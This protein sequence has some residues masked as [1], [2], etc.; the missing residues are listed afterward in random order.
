MT[1]DDPYT[2][3]HFDSATLVTI[4]VQRDFLSEA[5]HGVPGTTEVLPNLRAVIA[6]FRAARRP[7][8]HIVRLYDVGGANAE[9]S[10]RRLLESGVQLVAP[11]TPGSQLADGLAPPNAPE[12]D[13]D[14]LRAGEPQ[15]LG[16]D[17]YALFKP[18]WGAFYGTTLD[19]LLRTLG[20]DTLV[21]AG[22]NLPNCPRASIIEASERDYRVILVPDA[23]SRTTDTGLSEIAGLGVHLISTTALISHLAG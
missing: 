4:D 7:V 21:F 12:L 5:P 10:R 2:A 14:A 18:R 22:C 8:I 20:V 23:V 17:E 3:P 6:A 16:P 13:P 11:G 19:E 1:F 15:V 9:P